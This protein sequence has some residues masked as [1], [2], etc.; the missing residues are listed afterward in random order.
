MLT[1]QKAAVTG[2]SKG[3]GKFR[4]ASQGCCRNSVHPSPRL[5][6]KL[7]LICPQVAGSAIA[8][9]LAGEGAHVCLL[10]RSEE[11]LQD[12]AAR[13]RQAGAAGVSVFPCNLSNAAEVHRRRSGLAWVT[14]LV[15]SCHAN[16]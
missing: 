5:P 4:E 6:L 9:A 1:G 12:T 10:A 7:A 15:S 11:A 14:Q 2:A 8:E 13:C 16:L 3:I